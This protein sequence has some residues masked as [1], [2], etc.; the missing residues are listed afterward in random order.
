MGGETSR[1][2][3]TGGSES[4]RRLLLETW[5]PH[6]AVAWAEGLGEVSVP[7]SEETI[8]H[9]RKIPQLSHF[10]L[11]NRPGDL[12]SLSLFLN[13]E[14]P[15]TYLPPRVVKMDVKVPVLYTVWHTTERK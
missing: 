13:S 12:P 6:R 14:G 7:N 2:V 1:P 15:A 3:G 5:G 10:Q 8:G 11:G 4:N 9:S